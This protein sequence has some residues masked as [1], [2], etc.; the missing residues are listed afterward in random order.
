M[1][2]L[3]TNKDDITT[4]FVVKKLTEFGI[5]FY[6][7]N[8][9]DIIVN[10]EID[11]NLDQNSY[12]LFDKLLSEE[13]DL[14]SIKSVY[15][16]RPKFPDLSDQQISMG[17][18]RFF[19]NEVNYFFEAIYSILSEAYWV[20]PVYSIRKAENKM[21]QLKE[22]KQI[23][24]EIPESIISN[25]Y[26][27]LSMFLTKQ[28][29]NCIIKPIK[30]GFIEEEKNSKIIFTSEINTNILGGY[31]DTFIFPTY[32]QKKIDKKNDVRVTVVGDKVFSVMIYSQENDETKID[33]RK[34]SSNRIRHE[35]LV[36][37]SQLEEKCVLLT[38]ILGLKFGAIDLVLKPD[39]TYVF[40]E[41]N[42]NGQWAWIEKRLGYEISSE[43][44]SLLVNHGN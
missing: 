44:V 41:I 2:L 16:R 19:L 39:G 31:K 8:T 26:E 43:I 27:Y 30:T 25:K 6:R 37:P 23:G 34:S 40:L 42:P 15:F 28:R 36:L 22:A 11:F 14:G 18:K 1:I 5:K 33:W 21:L 35:K 29:N 7:L 17:E 32:L 9:E 3:I 38:K 12:K 4:D 13:I 10:Y 20:S 24:F